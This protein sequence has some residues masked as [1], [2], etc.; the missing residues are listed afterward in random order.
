M[1]VQKIFLV[2]MSLQDMLIFLGN[3]GNWHHDD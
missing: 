1:K 2:S 3:F